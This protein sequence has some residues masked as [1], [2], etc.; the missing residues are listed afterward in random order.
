VSRLEIERKFLV[1]GD[2]WRSAPGTLLRQGYLSSV[3]E[4]TVRVRL[5]DG[6]G[7]LTVKGLGAGAVREEFEFEIPADD[8]RALLD[9]LCER[10]ILEKTRRRVAHAGRTWEVDEFH[11]ENAGLVVAEV[12]LESAD[13]AVVLPPWAGAEVT[14]DPRY[15]N[16]NLARAPFRTWVQR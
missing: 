13:A 4:R 1:T 9:R 16:A 2:A 12:E 3:P 8:A 5:E 15:A 11:G 7:T 14:A 6:R 10:P